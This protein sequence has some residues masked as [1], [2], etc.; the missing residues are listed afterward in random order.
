MAAEGAKEELEQVDNYTALGL[1]IDLFSKVSPKHAPEDVHS[2][3]VVARS[4]TSLAT[5]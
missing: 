4:T 3:A 5:R 2:T 1:V